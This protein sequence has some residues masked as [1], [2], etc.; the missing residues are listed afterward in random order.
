MALSEAN[1][2]TN[3]HQGLY[4]GDGNAPANWYKGLYLDDTEVADNQLDPAG[5]G[6]NNPRP[7]GGQPVTTEADIMPLS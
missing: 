5:I 6:P 1:E 3:K 4:T 7:G 2:A